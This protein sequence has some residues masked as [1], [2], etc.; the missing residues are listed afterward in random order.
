MPLNLAKMSTMAAKR[1]RSYEKVH[2]KLQTAAS[3]KF[4]KNHT[5]LQNIRLTLDFHHVDF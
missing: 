2:Y 5:V 1:V 3:E 4:T